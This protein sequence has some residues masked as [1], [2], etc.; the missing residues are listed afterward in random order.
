MVERDMRHLTTQQQLL[1]QQQQVINSKNTF[2][3]SCAATK[4]PKVP[5][6][7]GIRRPNGDHFVEN[8]ILSKK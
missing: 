7:D 5:L 1:K 8:V 6:P 2:S 4:A 3:K